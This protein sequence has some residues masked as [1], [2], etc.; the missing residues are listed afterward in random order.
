MFSKSFIPF[1][2]H[3]AA[4]AWNEVN[5]QLQY[6]ILA[7]MKV[8]GLGF[9]MIA[10]LLLLFPLVTYFDGNPIIRFA[11]PLLAFLFC[12]GLFIINYRLYKQTKAKT[13][14]KGSLIAMLA[15]MLGILVTIKSL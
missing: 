6:V 2:E 14:W 4:I 1:H 3:A 10:I 11:I 12:G 15:I 13:P 5:K 7:I 8:S 9:L